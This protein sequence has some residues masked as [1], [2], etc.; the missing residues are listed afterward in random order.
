[1]IRRPIP[2]YL[3][4]AALLSSFAASA[5]EAP[6]PQRKLPFELAPTVRATLDAGGERAALAAVYLRY[7][8]DLVNDVDALDA[9][10]APDVKLHDIGRLGFTGLDGL[11]AFRRQRN[12]ELPYDRAVVQAMRFPS[13]GILEV[14]VCTE[15][16]E[17]TGTKHTILIHAR[18]RWAEG[19]LVERWDSFEELAGG[20]GCGPSAG[21]R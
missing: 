9:T 13:P 20:R 17:P 11:K 1:M 14:D 3:A 4:L 5:G 7:A 2:C 6:G 21:V 10:V 18:N 8:S 19:K 12:A 15:R 16:A